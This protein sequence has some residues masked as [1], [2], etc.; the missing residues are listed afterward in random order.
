MGNAPIDHYR[1]EQYLPDSDDWIE[2]DAPTLPSATIDGLTN[3][4]SHLFR[5]SAHNAAGYGPPSPALSLTPTG[6][7]TAPLNPVLDIEG[8]NEASWDPP[9]N[10]GGHPVDL[11]RVQYWTES[12]PGGPV[13]VGET[14]TA[15]LTVAV[16]AAGRFRVQAHNVL[17]WGDWSDHVSSPYF[18]G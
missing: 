17:G 4:R 16:S 18:S 13:T 3:G 5:V 14:T 8:I 9:A 15:A 1:V 6:R 12:F 10:D 11:Y 2:V 7:P